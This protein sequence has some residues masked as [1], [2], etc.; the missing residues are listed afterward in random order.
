MFFSV[1]ALVL[2]AVFYSE[3]FPAVGGK[4]LD[5][6]FALPHFILSY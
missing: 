2:T 6:F 3:R 5:S 1:A 4:K